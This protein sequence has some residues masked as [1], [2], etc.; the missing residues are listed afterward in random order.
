[1][2]NGLDPDQHWH[3]VYLFKLFFVGW[4]FSKLTPSKTFFQEYYQGVKRLEPGSGL[5]FCICSCF[6]RRLLTVSNLNF[7]KKFFQE[8]YQRVKWFESTSECQ[9]W[10]GSKLFVKVI[11]RWKKWP[12]ARKRNKDTTQWHLWG[13]NTRPFSLE[14]STLPL[15]HCA[16]SLKV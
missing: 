6:C 5:T 9:S 3:S 16:P 4:L 13:S 10:Y 14:S 15:S 1:M 7:F 11:S 8:H 2:S 12:L